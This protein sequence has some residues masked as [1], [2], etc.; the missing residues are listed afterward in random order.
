LLGRNIREFLFVAAPKALAGLCTVGINL[1]LLRFFGPEQ[2]GAYAL[3]VS[4]VLLSDAILGSALDLGVIRL[5]SLHHEKDPQRCLAVQ[6]AGFYLKVIC[7]L[8]VTMIMSMFA[9]R[10]SQMLFHR[11][12]DESLLYIVCAGVLALLS[13]RSLQMLPQINCKFFEYGLLELIQMVLK[14]GGITL[15]LIWGRAN[16]ASVLAL[17]AAGPFLAIAIFVAAWHRQILPFPTVHWPLV[18]ELTDL[19]KWYFLTFSISAL[20]NRADIFLLASWSNLREVG[21]YSA[22]QTFAFVPQLLGTYLSVLLSPRIMPRWESGQFFSFFR[23][24]QLAML[25][26]CAVLYGAAVLMIKTVGQ[27]I[28]P[29]SFLSSQQIILIL[30]PGA[31]AGLLTFPLTLTFLLFVKPRFLVAMD[32]IALPLMFLLY[33]YAIQEHGAL[34]AA[35]V[36]SGSFVAK[37]LIA[38]LKAWQLAH[39]SRSVTGVELGFSQEISGA[40]TG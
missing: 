16:A 18:R 39:S 26:V 21:L 36:T 22:A 33:R 2:Y 17:L 19:V 1:V 24:F 13:L 28:L 4:I 30:L 34:G 38:Q 6:A 35:W 23:R 27:K 11:R 8:V 3:C 12:G 37:A 14:Y 20:V 5:A 25:A 29:P 32:C 40:V 9:G 31:L 15:L 10:L 7:V